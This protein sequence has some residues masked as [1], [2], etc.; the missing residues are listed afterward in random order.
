MYD[1]CYEHGGNG[2][3]AVCK[4]VRVDIKI[5]GGWDESYQISGNGRF[6]LLGEVLCGAG[7]GRAEIVARSVSRMNTRTL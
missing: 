2:Y 1:T 7:G 5:H 6:G 4:R 3:W